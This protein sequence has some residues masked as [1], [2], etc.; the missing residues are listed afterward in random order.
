M[1]ITETVSRYSTVDWPRRM[2]GVYPISVDGGVRAT[3]A[4]CLRSTPRPS[5][6]SK[7]AIYT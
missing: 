5:P 4:R 2:P 1:L 3:I 6:S 7:R